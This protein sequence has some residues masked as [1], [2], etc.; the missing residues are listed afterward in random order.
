MRK[1]E[2]KLVVIKTQPTCTGRT[3]ATAHTGITKKEIGHI[4]MI[5]DA[6]SNYLRIDSFG[7]EEKYRQKGVGK[8]LIEAMVAEVKRIGGNTIIVYP[9]PECYA[10]EEPLDIETLYK[11][12]ERLGFALDNPSADYKRRDNKMIMH[13]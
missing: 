2:N 13:F 6:N 12:Y 9:N 11:V 7:V 10:D 8:K 1:D 3:S 5:A 4:C